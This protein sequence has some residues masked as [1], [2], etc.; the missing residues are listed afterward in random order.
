MTYVGVVDGAFTTELR[1]AVLRPNY[2]VGAP[3]FGDTDPDAI[4]LAAVDDGEAVSACVLVRRAYPRQPEV[5]N[6]WQLRAMATAEE[7]RGK[8]FGALVVEAALEEVTGHGAPLLWLEARQHAIGFYERFGFAAEGEVY[9]HPETRIPHR[10]MVRELPG[11]STSS[12]Q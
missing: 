9:L 6:A 5:E 3:M 7:H 4:H 2:A 12:S 1:R 10:V 11:A 8:G